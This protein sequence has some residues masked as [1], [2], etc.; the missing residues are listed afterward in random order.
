MAGVKIHRSWNLDRRICL[1]ELAVG[2]FSQWLESDVYAI[3]SLIGDRDQVV[4]GIFAIRGLS[5]TEF[6]FGVVDLDSTN[7][8]L[9]YVPLVIDRSVNF[10]NII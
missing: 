9:K 10:A 1:I 5:H 8:D 7:G 2:T 6:I 4:V 3:F